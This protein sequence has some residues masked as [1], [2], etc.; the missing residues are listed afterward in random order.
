MINCFIT[1]PEYSKKGNSKIAFL[2]CS[3]FTKIEILNNCAVTIDVFSFK[4]IE[5]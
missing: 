4:V 1:H 3:L 2:G 5:Q